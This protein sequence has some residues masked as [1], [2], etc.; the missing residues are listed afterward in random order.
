ME[1][2]LNPGSSD[3]NWELKLIYP[4]SHLKEFDHLSEVLG[5]SGANISRLRKLFGIT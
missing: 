2:S 1:L 5:L 3:V 4:T